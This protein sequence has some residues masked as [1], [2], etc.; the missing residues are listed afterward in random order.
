MCPPPIAPRYENRPHLEGL[1][2]HCIEYDYVVD[3]IGRNS[4]NI[5]L[6]FPW[7]FF[8]SLFSNLFSSLFIRFSCL[9]ALNL[10]K[11]QVYSD[12]AYK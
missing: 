7:C 8:L 1:R 2:R 10:W 3:M 6:T 11:K 12:H 4:S 9:L 5:F